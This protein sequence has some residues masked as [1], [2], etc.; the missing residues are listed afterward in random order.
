[1]PQ[2]KNVS[3]AASED[4]YRVQVKLSRAVLGMPA[5]M[6][7]LKSLSGGFHT[8]AREAGKAA[9]RW[10]LHACTASLH[11]DPLVMHACRILHKLGRPDNGL[12]SDEERAEIDITSWQDLMAGSRASWVTGRANAS[13]SYRGVGWSVHANTWKAQI[14]DKPLKLHINLGYFA[15]QEEAARAYDRAAHHVHGRCVRR[16]TFRLLRVGWIGFGPDTLSVN[17][18]R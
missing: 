3:K 18:A 6:Q 1:M 8:T 5:E 16:R 9:D 14:H 12:L 10:S 4:K 2:Y 7:H 15:S 13:S 11:C 17:C